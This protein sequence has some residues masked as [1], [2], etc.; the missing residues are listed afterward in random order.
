MSD[1]LHI[2]KSYDLPIGTTFTYADSP[3]LEV[4]ERNPDRWLCCTDCY[5]FKRGWIYCPNWNVATIKCTD[6]KDG[7]NVYFKESTQNAD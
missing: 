6:R 7:K 2:E 5:F 3:L 1:V 4:V